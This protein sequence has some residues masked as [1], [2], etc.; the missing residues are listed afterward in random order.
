LFNGEHIHIRCC[1]YILN[2]VVQDETEVMDKSI[3]LIR[4][5]ISYVIKVSTLVF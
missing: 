1:A 2:I 5:L 3:K 4:S